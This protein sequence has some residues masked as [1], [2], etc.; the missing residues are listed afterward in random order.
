MNKSLTSSDTDFTEQNLT[1]VLS[2]APS[3]YLPSQTNSPTIAQDEIEKAVLVVLESANATNLTNLEKAIDALL[4]QGYR[5]SAAPYEPSGWNEIWAVMICSIIIF[6]IPV[7]LSIFSNLKLR[8]SGR[9]SLRRKIITR[10]K[11]E[12]IC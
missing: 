9:I 2:F 11:R 7:A 6:I 1:D 12:N 8:S 4:S 10:G 3:Y 5:F